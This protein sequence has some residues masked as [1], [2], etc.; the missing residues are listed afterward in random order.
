MI[1]GGSQEQ[2]YKE[3][4]FTYCRNI[5]TNFWAVEI[6]KIE[7]SGGAF[8]SK[9]KFENQNTGDGI[10]HPLNLQAAIIDS[11]SS[12]LVLPSPIVSVIIQSIRDQLNVDCSFQSNKNIAHCSSSIEISRF[13]DIIFTLCG[14]EFK[15]PAKH[16]IIC[17]SFECVIKIM[18][19]P[20]SMHLAILGDTFMQ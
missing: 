3:K 16:Y 20:D 13:P 7:L 5:A 8:S 14:N 2:F 9:V 17:N 18:N 4:E 1:I 11:G 12:V 6:E 10:S 19:S 15:I